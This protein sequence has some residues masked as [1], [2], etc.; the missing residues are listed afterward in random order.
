MKIL[1]NTFK[2]I[3]FFLPA[4]L[5]G[6]IMVL[7]TTFH[8]VSFQTVLMQMT[9]PSLNGNIVGSIKIFIQGCLWGAPLFFISLKYYKNKN[10]NYTSKAC[11]SIGMTLLVF[12]FGC[13]VL[14]GAADTVAN[15]SDYS[16]IYEECY[17]SPEEVK[18]TFPKEKRNLLI[19]YLES[20]EVAY[21]GKEN[22]GATDTNYIPY[23][24]K[25]MQTEGQNFKGKNH[26]GILPVNG[27]AFTL[28]A[29]VS[30]SSGITYNFPTET[31][32]KFDANSLLSMDNVLVASNLD[33][34][35]MDD[36]TTLGDVLHDAG[37]YN[38][39]ICGTEADFAGRSVYYSKHN[40]TVYDI[41]AAINDYSSDKE[42]VANFDAI[43][44]AN[45]YEIVK[46]RINKANSSGKPWNINFL[47]VNTHQPDGYLCSNCEKT[48]DSDIEN[49]IVCAD[50]LLNDFILWAQEQD[51]HKNTTIIIL[52]DHPFMGKNP[53]I[54]DVESSA[55]STVNIFLNSANENID[56]M[57]ERQFCQLDMFPT[58]L[59]ALG[60]NIEGSKLGLGTDLYSGEPTL[61][62]TLGYEYVNNQL[63]MRSQMHNNIFRIEV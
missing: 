8:G 7:D 33:S 31:E 48:Y 23:I 24:T 25:L 54:E 18:L 9:V 62:E 44:D 14:P 2:L 10:K 35:F 42:I 61:I 37:Y 11:H 20:V 32:Y 21:S 28:G 45:M 30:S 55:R 63:G 59:S 34:K 22:G 60:V 56:N 40:Y 6:T 1:K 4:I 52:G 41:E 27:A 3:L 38:E 49:A 26:E 53:I 13:V 5:F 16:T 39:F 12:V 36:A 50:N 19:I 51:W 46:E 17:V 57:S 58:M 29:L 47:T 15:A 43:S